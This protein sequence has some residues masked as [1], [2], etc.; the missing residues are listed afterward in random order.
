[1]RMRVEEV[2]ALRAEGSQA[3]IKGKARTENPYTPE[4]DRLSNTPHDLWDKGWLLTSQWD[5]L[6]RKA[7]EFS[8][9][10][11]RADQG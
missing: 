4:P 5:A 6:I 10:N 8:N 7:V 11:L 3:C 1:M 2:L 9:E